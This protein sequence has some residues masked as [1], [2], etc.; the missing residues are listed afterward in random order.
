MQTHLMKSLN[1]EKSIVE[2][3]KEY[4]RK[5]NYKLVD[6]MPWSFEYEGNPITHETDECFLIPTLEGTMR[7]TPNHMLITGVKGEIYPCEID[8]FTQTYEKVVR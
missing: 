2:Y 6:G 4:C 5:R 8:I 7:M 1:M 3:G